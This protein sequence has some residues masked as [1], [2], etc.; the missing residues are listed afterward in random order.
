MLAACGSQY[1]SARRAWPCRWWCAAL[2]GLV[3]GLLIARARMAA[4]IV[5]LAALLFARGLA[6]AVTDEGATIFHHRQPARRHLARPGAIV[7]I[8]V[9]DLDR[10]RRVRPR[11]AGARADPLRQAVFAV[12]GSEDAARLMGLPVA[13]VK[14]ASTS[15]S[16]LLAGLAGLLIAARS[17]SGVTI[18]VGMELDA[19]AAVVIGGTLLTGGSGSIRGTLAGVL[20]LDVIQNLINQ[21]GTLN[22]YYQQ[23][24]SGGFLIVVVVVQRYL[25]R[26]QRL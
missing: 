21:V 6:F 19:I 16:G 9:P 1:G 12:G 10:R 17:S 2:I 20:L 3:N 13:R 4:F 22:S 14:I 18:G 23:V 24:V 5:T 25:S 8:R 7:G 26:E 15:S 11:R